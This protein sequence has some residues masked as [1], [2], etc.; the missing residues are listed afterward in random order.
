MGILYNDHSYLVYEYALV[1]NAANT[2]YRDLN[3]A[4]WRRTENNGRHV[5]NP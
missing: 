5:I 2:P 4:V 1:R 3:N